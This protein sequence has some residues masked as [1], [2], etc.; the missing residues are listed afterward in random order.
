M[1][2]KSLNKMW[3][4]GGKTMP[5][6]DF[7]EKYNNRLSVVYKSA[8][9]I[10]STASSSISAPSVSTPY[11]NYFDLGILLTISIGLVYSLSKK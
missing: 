5:F 2:N 3:R 7:A 6:K 11:G 4:E 1:E 10:D 8:T 9:G